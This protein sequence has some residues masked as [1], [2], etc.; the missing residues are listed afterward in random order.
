VG[1]NNKNRKYSIN[2]TIN[3]WQF[4]L[5]LVSAILLI[6]S[7]WQLEI[8]FIDI[9]RHYPYCYPFDIY[10]T[11]EYWIVRDIW[12]FFIFFSW[13]LVIYAIWKWE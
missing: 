1:V 9:D 7:V 4:L 12:Y 10:C 8:I 13:A 3:K 6:V 2:D 11:Y 5:A